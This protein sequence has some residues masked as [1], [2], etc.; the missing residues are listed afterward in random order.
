MAFTLQQ[1]G[2]QATYYHAALD[3]GEKLQNA[4]LWLEGKAHIICCTFAF[5]MG[6]DIKDVSV[7]ICQ[8]RWSNLFKKVAEQVVMVTLPPERFISVSRI[9]H[10][11]YK[12]SHQLITFKSSKN[13]L[14]C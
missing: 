12:T 14:Y 1:H 6:I 8:D 2:L 13:S 4:K 3:E 11:I 10:S 7:S 9:E 5:G